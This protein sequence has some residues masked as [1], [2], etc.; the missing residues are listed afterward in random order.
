MR[1]AFMRLVGF[2][3]IT[4]L[5]SFVDLNI[6]FNGLAMTVVICGL[7]LADLRPSEAS[8][9]TALHSRAAL[10]FGILV[11]SV[12]I[13]VPGQLRR[14][15][16]E[17]RLLPT[18]AAEFD[19][20]VH[21]LKANPGSAICESILL[22][23]E[24]DKPLEFEAFAVREQVRTGAT[25]EADVLELLKTHHFQTIQVELRSDEESLDV[26]ELRASLNSDQHA[27][28]TERRFSPAFMGEL[29]KDYHFS[30]RTSTM[31]VF[32]AN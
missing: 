29:L 3:P 8:Q 4:A 21:V 27:P 17:M 32:S 2:K 22:C 26:T 11:F 15:R 19:S 31:A 6:F 9:T 28:D 7:A 14:D 12:M 13:F 5:G 23:Y 20:A 1:N 16:Q 10:A 18:S 24:A 30:L 25:R